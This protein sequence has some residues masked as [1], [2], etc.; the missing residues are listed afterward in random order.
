[1]KVDGADVTKIIYGFH[2]GRFYNVMAYFGSES[3]YTV[4]KESFSREYGEPLQTEQNAMKC[5]W[6]GETASVLLT[7]DDASKT[8]RIAFFF[9]PIQIEVEMS[10]PG[11]PQ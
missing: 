8:G 10:R 9:K 4:L 11:E 1:M 7:W 6:N 3:A 5:F 2:K